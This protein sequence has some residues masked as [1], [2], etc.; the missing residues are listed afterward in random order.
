MAGWLARRRRV[1]ALLA[2]ELSRRS[3]AR[4]V[5]AGALIGCVAGEE[6]ECFCFGV[7][8]ARRRCDWQG[9]PVCVLILVV[10]IVWV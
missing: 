2:D 10:L 9:R 8:A 4:Q 3:R 6:Q 1:A 5:G 7:S